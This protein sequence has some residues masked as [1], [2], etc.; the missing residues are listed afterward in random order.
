MTVR[1]LSI[2][3]SKY[4]ELIKYALNQVERF[5]SDE[6]SLGAYNRIFAALLNDKAQCFIMWDN[7]KEVKSLAVTEILED[8]ITTRRILNIRCLYAFKNTSNDDWREGF[9]VIKELASNSNCKKIVF[10][11]SNTRVE[12]IGKFLG[13]SK[14]SVNLEM[15]I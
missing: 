3:I 15:E 2:Q 6:E 4:W 1:L 12:G 10:Q 5:G 13:F 14:R 9:N 11:T 7:N 8:F